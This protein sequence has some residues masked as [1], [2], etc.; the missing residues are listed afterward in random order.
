M[1]RFRIIALLL[2][3][4]SLVGLGGCNRASAEGCEDACNRLRGLA[5][6]EFDKISEALPEDKRREGW[7]QAAPVFEDMRKGCVSACM[8]GGTK[9]LVDC[10]TA[11]Q[12]ANAWRDCIVER[13]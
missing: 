5:R 12:S 4:I 6:A 1:G 9:E 2:L 11:A 7:N 8:E 10:L 13:R 3:T